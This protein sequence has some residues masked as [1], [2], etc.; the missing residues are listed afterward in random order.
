MRV[1]GLAL[2][3]VALYF[4]AL[5]LWKFYHSDEER[6]W[7]R[8]LATA[9]DSAT[10]LVSRLAIIFAGLLANLDDVVGTIGLDSLKGYIDSAFSSP[11]TTGVIIVLIIGL[12]MAAR[13]RTL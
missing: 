2:A 3:A 7:D 13:K 12:V 6:T 4:T 5:T 9:K 8:L 10:M 1:I 11:K